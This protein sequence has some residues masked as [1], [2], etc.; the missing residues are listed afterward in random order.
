MQLKVDKPKTQADIARD[1]LDALIEEA[2]ADIRAHTGKDLKTLKLEA[3]RAESALADKK[4]ELEKLASSSGEDALEAL[5]SELKALEAEAQI[6][7]KALKQAVEE[8]GLV[9]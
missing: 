2:K 6:A 7:R 1:A 5:Q 4:L 9:E 8:Q 3:A